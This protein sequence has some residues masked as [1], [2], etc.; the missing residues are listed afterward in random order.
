MRMLTVNFY[1]GVE[2]RYLPVFLYMALI[3]C[4]SSIP[5]G[6]KADLIFSYHLSSSLQ[7]LLHVPGFG[8]L[9]YLWMWT[10]RDRTNFTR[11][12]LFTLGIT[13]LYGVLDELYQI[14]IPGRIASLGDLLLNTAGVILGVGIYSF[15]GRRGPSPNS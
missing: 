7:N 4:L 3:L 14:L 13:T 11:G 12:A 2:I 6:S 5:G 8:L 9:A 10:L 15:L 1:K